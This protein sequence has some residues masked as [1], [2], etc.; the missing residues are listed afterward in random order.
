MNYPYFGQ[1]SSMSQPS[2]SM[3]QGQMNYNPSTIASQPLFPQPNGNV[4]NINNTLEVANVP[5]GVGLSVAL[6]LPENLMYIKTMQ[7]GSPMFWAYR[8]IPYDNK[9][10]NKQN[11]TVD[12]EISD[13]E[14]INLIEELKV[15]KNKIEAL[16]KQIVFIK[17]R[18][19]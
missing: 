13:S 17:K 14:K 19:Q 4:Y 10:E 11:N 16:E 3:G 6:C 8:I 15:Y 12:S 18:N 2:T 7:N 1:S 5:A 9:N